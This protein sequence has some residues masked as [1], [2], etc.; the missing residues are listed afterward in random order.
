VA[1]LI[2][3]QIDGVHRADVHAGVGNAALAAV[4]DANLLGR[5]GVA[6]IGDD[7]DQ[8]L[9][10]ILLVGGGLADHGAQGLLGA[11][12]IQ[13]HAQ[14]Q[15]HAGG[16][17]GTL[18]KHAVAVLCNFAGNQLIGD[19]VD[20]VQIVILIAQSGDFFKYVATDIVNNAMYAS[21]IYLPPYTMDGFLPP[22]LM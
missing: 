18:L 22:N 8:R 16:N 1:A 11:L 13:I 2:L 10:E 6:G 15:T 14:C 20:P 9:L 4:G 5:A 3:V 21:H 7:V 19:G 17:H 12:G